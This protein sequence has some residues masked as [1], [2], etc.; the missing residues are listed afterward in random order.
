MSEPQYIRMS[1]DEQFRKLGTTSLP[2]PNEPIKNMK[3]Y[4]V[5]KEKL[6]ML[7]EKTEDGYDVTVDTVGVCTGRLLNAVNN[8]IKEWAA[9]L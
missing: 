2:T 7:I 4:P 1:F 6:P 9:N 3:P 5:G 8:H